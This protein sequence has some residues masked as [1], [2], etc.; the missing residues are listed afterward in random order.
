MHVA[1]AV[2]KNEM[3][4]SRSKRWKNKGVVQKV[5]NLTKIVRRIKPEAKYADINVL[6]QAFNYDP[7]SSYVQNLFSGMSQGTT[8]VNNYT[9]DEL[10]HKGFILRGTLY[11]N[12]SIPFLCKILLVRVKTNP[13]GLI[14]T[15]NIGNIVKESTY[16]GGANAL[17]SPL[18]HDN[19]ANFQVMRQWKFTLN[20]GAGSGT[21]TTAF[22]KAIQFTRYVKTNFKVSFRAGGNIPAKNGLYLFFMT[23]TT[24]NGVLNYVLRHSYT[25]S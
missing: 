14:T 7:T 12:S 20:P 10:F 3:R 9:G 22:P 6:S 16:L 17:N 25:D 13:E 1:R 4:K 15:T 11:N 19:K 18:D 5:K 24:A 2:V 21:G 23:D 8:D